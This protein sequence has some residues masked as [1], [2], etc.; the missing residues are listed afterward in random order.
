MISVGGAELH[1]QRAEAI[2]AEVISAVFGLFS[3]GAQVI[4]IQGNAKQIRWNK[5]KLSSA[6]PYEAEDRAVCA[7]DQP[8]LP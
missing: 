8:S 2:S 6:K 5:A 4:G 1:T 7:G 3:P